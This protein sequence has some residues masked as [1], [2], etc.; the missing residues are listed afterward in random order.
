MCQLSCLP[1]PPQTPRKLC[2]KD[3]LPKNSVPAGAPWVAMCRGR[4]WGRLMW[5]RP[6]GSSARGQWMPPPRP[7]RTQ[8]P[9]HEEPP[10]E[11]TPSFTEHLLCAV[12]RVQQEAERP[13]SVGSRPQAGRRF[14]PNARNQNKVLGCLAGLLG[15]ASMS[16]WVHKKWNRG[17]DGGVG[18]FLSV[19]LQGALDPVSVT[20]GMGPRGQASAGSFWGSV[21]NAGPLSTEQDRAFSFPPWPLLV[22]FLSAVPCHGL[23]A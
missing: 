15:V 7:H 21:Q 11:S 17:Q 5:Q 10:D 19:A 16:S 20:D 3:N 13:C 8:R 2:W 1:A 14:P 23:W 18:L 6:T 12:L 22:V 9:Q 4:G